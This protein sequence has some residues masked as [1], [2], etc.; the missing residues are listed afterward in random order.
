MG[1]G[2]AWGKRATGQNQDKG[3]RA[4]WKLPAEQPERSLFVPVTSRW[5]PGR[6]GPPPGRGLGCPR[7]AP[8]A[9]QA[10]VGTAACWRR[11]LPPFPPRLTAA[12]DQDYERRLL[13]QIV[14]QNE[15][16][17]PSVSTQGCPAGAVRARWSWG[18]L[19]R[20][21]RAAAG[22]WPSENRGAD[23]R[24]TRPPPRRHGHARCEIPQHLPALPSVSGATD[25]SSSWAVRAEE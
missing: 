4:R 24:Q 23:R 25:P 2:G 12:M 10:A 14:I 8:C 13:R 20:G 22:L 19:G 15:N 17:M 5:A 9:R 6:E 3:V 11:P 1:D 18:E 21:G 7:G 16:T